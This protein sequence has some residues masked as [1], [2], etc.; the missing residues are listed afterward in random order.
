[1]IRFVRNINLLFD[2][3]NKNVHLQ[4]RGE[5]LIL[6]RGQS[7]PFSFLSY[8]FVSKDYFESGQLTD[9]IFAHEQAHVR[10]R[11]TWDNLLI[12]ALLVPFWF[13]PGLYLAR[14]A[15]KLN[16]EFIADDAALHVTPLD[17]YKSFLL[18]MMLPDQNQAWSA[19][20]IFTSP[21]KRFEMMKRRTANSAKWI[22]IL[23]LIP[24]LV[25]LVYV[26]SEKVTAIGEKK[27]R[28]G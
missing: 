21:K 1:M 4:F 7:M 17:Q 11:H 24:V 25:A 10:G 18:A 23:S 14:Q 8:I 5:T 28:I 27:E 13:H 26:F 22:M 2:K 6:L 19:A 20:L 16:H 15:I 9:S 12:E 3:I